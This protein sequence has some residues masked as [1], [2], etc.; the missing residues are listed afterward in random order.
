M[1]RWLSGDA[2]WALWGPVP[3]GFTGKC[4]SRSGK[5]P[6]DGH[7]DTK[8]L[9]RALVLKQQRC[10]EGGAGSDLFPL[11]HP[12]SVRAPGWGRGRQPSP[13]AYCPVTRERIQSQIDGELSQCVPKRWDR[14]RAAP[15]SCSPT[16]E[17]APRARCCNLS[18]LLR[19]NK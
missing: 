18:L 10:E 8:R 12:G 17:P 9:G 14:G 19:M 3:L 2:E 6:M 11:E 13:A 4:W 5:R 1:L 16:P 15:S 7:T